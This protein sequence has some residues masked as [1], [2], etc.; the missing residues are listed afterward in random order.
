MKEC[1]GWSKFATA[2]SKIQYNKLINMLNEN[3]EHKIQHLN[4]HSKSLSDEKALSVCR[5]NT[6]FLEY[7]WMQ[8]YN[9]H[10]TSEATGT[11]FV[12]ADM[13]HLKSWPGENFLV[14]TAYH[15]VENAIQ[16]LVRIE[17]EGSKTVSSKLIACN[18]DLDVAVVLVPCKL[19]TSIEP[20][21]IGKSDEI[22]PLDQ[23]QALGYAMGSSH[24][25]YTTGVISGRIPDRIQIDAA[26]NK[27]NSGGPLILS[28]SKAVIGIIV[29]ARS[30]AQNINYAC[31]IFEA[32][33]SL[34]R[35]LSKV[36]DQKSIASPIFERTPSLNFQIRT[37]PQALLKHMN[38]DHGAICV[39]VHPES[40]AYKKGIREGDLITSVNGY[41]VQYDCMIKPIYWGNRPLLWKSLLERL[42]L[43]DDV[44]ISVT[45]KNMKKVNYSCTLDRNFS[46]FRSMWPEFE[47]NKYIAKGGLIVQPLISDLINPEINKNFHW[48][49]SN[50]VNRPHVKEKS[51]LVIT[52]VLAASPFN[53]EQ[54]VSVGDV[55]LCLN[56]IDVN[57]DVATSQFDQYVNAWNVIE[58]NDHPLV[59]ICLRDGNIISATTEA[60]K[61][62]DEHTV[63][64]L[65]IALSDTS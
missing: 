45:K 4:T 54:M 48:R 11:G 55:I 52:H 21:D 8:P 26:I 29:S 2:S 14:F 56:D 16:I 51:F 34:G 43:G 28:S 61:K 13:S 46:T 39:Y 38:E 31:P 30:S 62:C 24:L 6:T 37:T 3:I 44:N 7:D 27:G 49:F 40:D 32:I 64:T 20:L 60:C 41:A 53:R 22:N 57:R 18:P 5:I 47:T 33:K 25:Q 9:K 50:I 58:N 59:T 17:A 10:N 15:V 36:Q 23:I 65:K 19:P 12:V 1:H 63:N 35:M 42:T